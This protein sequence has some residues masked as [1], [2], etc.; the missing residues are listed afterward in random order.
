[1][2]PGP[3]ITEQAT[4]RLNMDEATGHDADADAYRRAAARMLADFECRHGR[5]EHDPTPPCGCWPAE[6][7]TLAP[8]DLAPELAAALTDRLPKGKP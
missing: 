1:M 4:M 7:D 5:L 6:L 3:D 8:A 2:T